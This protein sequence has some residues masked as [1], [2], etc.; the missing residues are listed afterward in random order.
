MTQITTGVEKTME[1]R[2][3]LMEIDR[4]EDVYWRKMKETRVKIERENKAE[5]IVLKRRKMMP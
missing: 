1:K 3:R 4:N 5:N 2:A